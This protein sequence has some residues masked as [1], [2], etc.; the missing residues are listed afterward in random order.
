MKFVTTDLSHIYVL[1]T[2]ENEQQQHM[3]L[4]K[5]Q[6]IQQHRRTEFSQWRTMHKFRD[7]CTSYNMSTLCQK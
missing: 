7:H 2:H 6:W 3:K 5:T 4:N 1:R